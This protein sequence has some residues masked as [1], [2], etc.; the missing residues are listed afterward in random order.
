MKSNDDLT[1]CQ[2]CKSACC[3]YGGADF[4]K[5]EMEAVLKAGFP[6]YFVRIEEDHYEMKCEKGICPYLKT[7]N[8]CLIG[9]LRPL[10]CKSFPVYPETRN[11]KT[12]FFLIECP[13]ASLLPERE[14]K[15][16]KNQAFLAKEIITNTFCKSKLPG[17]DLEL[18]ERR[19]NRFNKKII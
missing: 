7:D 6:D 17:D 15:M 3:K 9:E 4:S 18:I 10:V 19:F 14:I 8:T 2:K 16:M 11:G 12:D 13:L 1:I 5:A